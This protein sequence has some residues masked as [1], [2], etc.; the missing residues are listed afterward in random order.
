MYYQIGSNTLIVTILNSEIKLTSEIKINIGV[1]CFDQELSLTMMM[2]MIVNSKT[3]SGL[4]L[5]FNLIYFYF[6]FFKSLFW[7]SFTSC[8]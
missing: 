7:I 8:V 1:K 4:H 5:N 6:H 2:S 3:E